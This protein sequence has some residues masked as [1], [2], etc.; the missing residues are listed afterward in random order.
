MASRGPQNPSAQLLSQIFVALLPHPDLSRPCPVA[1]PSRWPRFLRSGEGGLIPR[2]HP[3]STHFLG[4]PDARENPSH[5][6]GVFSTPTCLPKAAWPEEVPDWNPALPD[7]RVPSL[8]FLCHQ[9]RH[10]PGQRLPALGL[11][12]LPCPAS[13]WIRASPWAL[14]AQRVILSLLQGVGEACLP[15]PHC[16]VFFCAVEYLC[17]RRPTGR[18]SGGEITSSTFRSLGPGEANLP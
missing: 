8:P 2:S 5:S 11:N 17:V 1:L 18:F 16:L 6:Q 14:P 13:V 12:C 10:G 9:L 7:H 4:T 3:I 15:W